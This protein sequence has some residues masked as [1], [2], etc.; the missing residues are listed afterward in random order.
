MHKKRYIV[1]IVVFIS[2]IILIWQLLNTND[3]IMQANKNMDM[4]G[5]SLLIKEDTIKGL[6]NERFSSTGGF[7]CKPY[8]SESDAV[9]IVFSGFPDA[10]DDY[11]LTGITTTNPDYHFYGI[12]IGDTAGAA[13]DILS[14]NDFSKQN[15]NVSKENVSFKKGKLYVSLTVDNESKITKI[16]IK[17][18]STNKK[19]VVF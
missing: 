2:I 18:E 12:H 17:L 16:S 14:K 11:K 7:G 13:M 9:E 5:L 19:N 8:S 4:H 15:M 1:L 6:L 10:L 3:Y